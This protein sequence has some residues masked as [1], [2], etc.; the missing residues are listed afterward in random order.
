ML[1]YQLNVNHWTEGLSSGCIILL[2][3]W[4]KPPPVDKN[5]QGTVTGSGEPRLSPATTRLENG[6]HNRCQPQSP[7]PPT[8][9]PGP[10]K[11]L[12]K[13]SQLGTALV[14]PWL[15]HRAPNAGG[16][17]LIPGQGTRSHT[18]QVRIRM[19]QLKTENPTSGLGLPKLFW[20]LRPST[21]K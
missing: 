4:P 17:G 5:H 11:S 21:A 1:I 20:P 7:D 14:V 19:P 13:P 16:P 8:L 2:H 18:L 9:P 10:A 15:R 6:P 3:R 12:F